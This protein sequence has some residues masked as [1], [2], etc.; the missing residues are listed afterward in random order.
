M[1]LYT[2]MEKRDAYYYDTAELWSP[3]LEAVMF[4]STNIG[5]LW[6]TNLQI[7]NQLSPSYGRFKV[8]RLVIYSLEEQ[9][10]PAWQLG[11]WFIELLVREMPQ[12]SAPLRDLW[13]STE[14]EPLS[15][16]SPRDRFEVRLAPF[17]KAEPIGAVRVVLHGVEHAEIR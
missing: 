12:R 7:G 13:G 10:P 15:I 4:G 5:D 17:P 11:H 6:K 14:I 3:P 1:A 16:Q 9:E 2:P 8:N